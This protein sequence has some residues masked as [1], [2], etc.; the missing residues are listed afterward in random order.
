M[1]DWNERIEDLIESLK[2]QR[3]EL[4]VKM[5]LGKAEAKEEWSALDKKLER[6]MADAKAQAK[7]LQKA[8]GESAKDIGSA[9][10]LVGEEIQ[11]G[12]KRIRD[13]LKS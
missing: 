8:A 4:R 10:E 6:L 2:Q 7:P 3:D 13:I 11:Q 5:S 1:T 12:Y 9:L